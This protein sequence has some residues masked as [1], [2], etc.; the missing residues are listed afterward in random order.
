MAKKDKILVV[1]PY[2]SSFI[3]NDIKIISSQ[4]DI[5]LNS[6]N[7]KNKFYVPFFLVLQFLAMFKYLRRARLILIE[8]GGYWALVPSILGKVFN[9]PVLI[10]LHGTDCASMPHIQYG[11]LR[12]KV[13]RLACKVSYN[14]A[15]ALLPVSD[16]LIYTKNDYNT[17]DIYQGVRH[18]FPNTKTPFEVIHN[19]LDTEFWKPIG[20]V[21]REDNRFIA[22]FSQAQFIL[23]GGD[24]IMAL[25]E[26]FPDRNFYI[27]GID[28]PQNL[29]NTSKNVHFLGKLSKEELR[30]EFEKSTFH[31]QLSM[32]EGFGLALCE[33]MLCECIPIG[34]SVNIIPE[35]I[36]DTGFIL[37]KKDMAQLADVIEKAD[38]V[39]NKVELGQKAR[40]HIMDNF[41]LKKKEELLLNTINSFV[42]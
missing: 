35:I 31:L 1:I 38:A 7:W 20:N 34:S 33:A 5:I 22:V 37:Q 28:A 26:K 29:S 41:S 2:K 16:S 36:G 15:T 23:K 32:Y 42:N 10:V 18:H 19:G 21:I 4:Y 40:K 14:L 6:Y 13:L 24:L 8:F 39:E 27:A 3:M 9:I 11:N 30:E 17:E 12:K 25:A